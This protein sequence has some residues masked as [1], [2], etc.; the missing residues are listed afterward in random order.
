[1]NL[2]SRR[3]FL[4]ALS[5]SAVAFAGTRSS[6]DTIALEQSKQEGLYKL[7]PQ[8]EEGPFYIAP[9][10]QRADIREGKSGVPLR[11][12]LTVIEVATSQ[13]LT[14]ARVDIWHCDAQGIY[15][16]Y[17]GQGDNH[18]IDT[19][20]D[21]FLRGSQMTDGSGSAAFDTIYPGWYDGR[22]THIH[23]K[24]YL[25]D[26]NVLTGQAFFPDALNEFLYLNVLAYQ[27]R[28]SNRMVVNANDMIVSEQDPQRLGFCSIREARD[29]Y[30]ASLI[31]GIDRA[32]DFAKAPPTPPPPAGSVLGR[33]FGRPPLPKL[34]NRTA[35]LVPGLIQG[36]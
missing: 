8:V 2:S 6:A 23:F 33:L 16:A 30:E 4:R 11:F 34:R 12:K 31:V 10:L 13:P 25:G 32:A 26:R 22:A 5:T 17:P 24:I 27:G 15:S 20:N 14:N 36:Q 28:A 1:M 18:R 35:A 7:T 19:S 29:H 9:Q 21:R 3:I